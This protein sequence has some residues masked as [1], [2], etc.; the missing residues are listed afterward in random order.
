MGA[1]RFSQFPICAGALRLEQRFSD[2]GI[3]L[4]L[5]A[6]HLIPVAFVE[7]HRGVLGRIWTVGYKQ[8]IFSFTKNKVQKIRRKTASLAGRFRL[9][10]RILADCRKRGQG[11]QELD[12]PELFVNGRLKGI[13]AGSG[14][15]PKFGPAFEG[16][17]VV[18]AAWESACARMEP[19]R[20]E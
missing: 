9:A 11:I 7:S 15:G 6:C 10:L 18:S 17:A 4:S 13:R 20:N 19:E 2:F 3:I 14:C 16:T 1:H 8:R 5:R 12:S